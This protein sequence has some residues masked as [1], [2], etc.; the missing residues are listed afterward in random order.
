MSPGVVFIAGIVSVFVGM[1]I[2]YV[3]IKVTA[4]VVERISRDKKKEA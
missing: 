4:F 3:S 2:I 1:S